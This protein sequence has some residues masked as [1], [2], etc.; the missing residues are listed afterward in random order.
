MLL[1]QT[2]EVLGAEHPVL[3]DR[4]GGGIAVRIARKQFTQR[5]CAS[6]RCNSFRR[7][8]CTTLLMLTSYF[9]E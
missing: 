6:S 8:R 2:I 7:A 5:S 1:P 9:S 4:L 3:S